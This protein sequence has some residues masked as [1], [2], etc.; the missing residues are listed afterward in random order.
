M[1]A[2]EN[3]K[4]WFMYGALGDSSRDRER[5]A[6][7]EKRFTEIGPDGKH[8]YPDVMPRS[9]AGWPNYAKGL[10]SAEDAL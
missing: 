10:L 3:T 4:P 9:S 7:I 1:S 2:G 5:A 8:C 6:L